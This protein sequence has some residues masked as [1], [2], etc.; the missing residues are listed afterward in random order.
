MSLRIIYEPSGRA[1]EYAPL[2]CNTQIGCSHACRFCYGPLAA[3][4]RRDDFMAGARVV[5][6]VLPRLERDAAEMQAAG[7]TRTTLFCFLTDPYQVDDPASW[8]LTSQCLGIMAEHGRPFTVLT[9]NGYAARMDF[10]L[11][12]P[13]R[14]TFATSIV[15][16]DDETRANWEPHA[17]PLCERWWALEE[18]IALGIDTWISVEPVIHPED[19]LRVIRHADETGVGHVK[20]GPLNYHSHRASVDWPAFGEALAETLA[21]LHNLRYYLKHEMRQYMPPD[22]PASTVKEGAR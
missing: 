21:G 18:A 17:G 10:G 6:D 1:G 5:K 13:T 20:I 22:F 4:R 15:H 2:A 16:W 7:D 12:T 19:A 11:Y 8:E 3:H 14:D 9:K